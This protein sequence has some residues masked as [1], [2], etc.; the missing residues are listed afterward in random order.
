MR[1]IK[2]CIRILVARSGIPD[3]VC[4]RMLT[5]AVADAV[6]EAQCR[7]VSPP[8][9]MA[10]G[11]AANSEITSFSGALVL[12]CCTAGGGAAGK[13]SYRQVRARVGVG[14]IPLIRYFVAWEHA[15]LASAH[16]L[17]AI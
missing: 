3:A 10:P 12:A 16:G 15:R 9:P 1:L 11:E 4:T 2:S 8:L 7:V 17:T 14:G 5:L 13:V 6:L